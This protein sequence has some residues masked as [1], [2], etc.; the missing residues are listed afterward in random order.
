MAITLDSLTLPDDCLWQDEFDWC[1]VMGSQFMTLQGRV[2][3]YETSIAYESGRPITLGDDDAWITR[4]DLKTLQS[5]AGDR[6][7]RMSLTLHDG[8]NYT[9][10]F[11][12]SD[13]PIVEWQQVL[14]T[15]D[16]NDV[17]VYRLLALKLVVV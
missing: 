16:P 1:G 7:K 5:W 8:R 2:V 12:H 17:D 14:D 13:S 6:D 11:R 10:A 3:L 9:V 4:A 15:A